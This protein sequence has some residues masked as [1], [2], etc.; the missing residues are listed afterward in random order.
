M[1]VSNIKSF[2]KDSDPLTIERAAHF[3]LEEKEKIE[4]IVQCVVWKDGRITFGWCGLDNS[5]V[6]FALEGAKNKCMQEASL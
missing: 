4:G 2:G 3:L 1:E 5:T 6:V